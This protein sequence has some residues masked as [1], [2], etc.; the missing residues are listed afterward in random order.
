MKQIFILTILSFFTVILLHAQTD[1]VKILTSAQCDMC[2]ETIENDL[3]FTKG[4]K[5]SNLDVDS[6]ILTVIYN[7]EKTNPE[8][9]REAVTK[10]GY[11]A[12]SLQGDP[13]AYNRLPDC[14]KKQ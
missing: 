4:V 13:K 7:S 2:K 3:S 11:D 5:K 1:T 10:S 8:K 12:D 9:I 14:C 6:K